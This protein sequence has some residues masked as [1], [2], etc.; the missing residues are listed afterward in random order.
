MGSF[1]FSFPS[2]FPLD[3][4]LSAPF[5]LP[6]WRREDEVVR[7]DEERDDR[8]FVLLSALEPERIPPKDREA[9]EGLGWRLMSAA[10]P[11][12]VLTP[13]DVAGAGADPE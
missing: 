9:R 3:P 12:L 6:L 13:R 5:A 4:E 10:L 1:S 11:V 8:L 2:P 7:D